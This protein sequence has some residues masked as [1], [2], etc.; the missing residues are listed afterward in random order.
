MKYQMKNLKSNEMNAGLMR[1]MLRNKLLTRLKII[2]YMRHANVYNR[3][4]GLWLI[5]LN[6]TLLVCVH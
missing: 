5:M 1:M 4:N 3:F 2:A 6:V